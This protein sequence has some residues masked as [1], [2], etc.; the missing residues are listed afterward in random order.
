M[1]SQG[2]N[3]DSNEENKDEKTLKVLL[4]HW[5]NHNKSHQENFLKWVDKAEEMG[6][7]KT[8]QF[9]KKA[10]EY[11]EKANEMLLEAKKHM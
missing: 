8:A 3:A 10:N 9:I 7:D 6:K 5:V 1:S 11:I 4:V 2:L